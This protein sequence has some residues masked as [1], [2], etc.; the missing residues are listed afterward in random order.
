MALNSLSSS[1]LSPLVMSH[2]CI[3]YL[4]SFHPSHVLPFQKYLY[5]IICYKESLSVDIHILVQV[6]S[7]YYPL[8]EEIV[9][10]MESLCWAL[11]K[12][13]S[14]LKMNF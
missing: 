8:F 11:V 3:L 10:K 2:D 7:V 13:L 5:P 9:F 14:T 1:P 4:S 12:A 6:T